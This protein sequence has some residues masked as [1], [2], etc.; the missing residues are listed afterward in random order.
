MYVI[1]V[2][3]VRLAAFT[4]MLRCGAGDELEV[5]VVVMLRAVF[6]SC[7]LCLLRPKRVGL[8]IFCCCCAMK[9][10]CLRAGTGALK[11]F[12]C[13]VNLYILSANNCMMYVIIQNNI[14]M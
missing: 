8:F 11:Y 4:R 10:F 6:V 3:A 14:I 7:L 2:E 12:I 13:C 5:L 1:I 9:L